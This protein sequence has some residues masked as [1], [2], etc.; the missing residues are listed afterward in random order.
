MTLDIEDLKKRILYRCSYRGS[1][2]M[3]ILMRTF[4]KS[5]IDQLNNKNLIELNDLV[6]LDDE[7][8]HKIKNSITMTN[9]EQDNEIINMFRKFKI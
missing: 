9:N 8:L 5:I 3:D 1:K 4:V 6:N 7:N 2:E